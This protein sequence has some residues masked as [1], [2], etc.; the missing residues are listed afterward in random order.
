M[1]AA[2]TNTS[3]LDRANATIEKLVSHLDNY[4]QACQTPS[5]DPS[6]YERLQQASIGAID[7]DLENIR[8][9]LDSARTRLVSSVVSSEEDAAKDAADRKEKQ[10]ALDRAI[11][12]TREREA[13]AKKREE[14]LVMAITYA[15]E[16]EA[17]A[18]KRMAEAKK[19]MA[20][21]EKMTIAAQRAS[22]AAVADQSKAD[23]ELAG[24][25]S[26]R[27]SFDADFRQRSKRL[28]EE[29][30]RIMERVAS[31]S[32]SEGRLATNQQLHR[33]LELATQQRMTDAHALMKHAQD[34]REAAQKNLDTAVAIDHMT[35]RAEDSVES[36]SMN[37][38][39]KQVDESIRGSID[40]LCSASTNVSRELAE[41][42]TGIGGLRTVTQAAETVA[43][44]LVELQ[45]ATRRLVAEFD[46]TGK[47]PLSSQ[48]ERTGKRA[49]SI[50]SVVSMGSQAEV[51]PIGIVSGGRVIRPARSRRSTSA[52][53]GPSGSTAGPSGP[54]NQLAFLTD[55][56]SSHGLKPGFGVCPAD[57]RRTDD[58]TRRVW[59][60]ISFGTGWT[61]TDSIRL[62]EEF[63]TYAAK[64]VSRTMPYNTL[65][66]CAD[67][68]GKNAN[69]LLQNI[70]KLGSHWNEG[71][72]KATKQCKECT[73]KSQICIRV[74]WLG[75][76]HEAYD[77]N[78]TNVKRWNVT[79]R[80]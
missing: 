4:R 72:D 7:K 80:Q 32:S 38:L 14:R 64:G 52:T 45:G 6:I 62:L 57:I 71:E 5:L 24:M 20:D 11:L 3:D 21:A 15:R 17:E 58:E 69:C 8:Q 76:S 12:T 70:R 49:K 65:D 1:A 54:S 37:E 13:D 22:D 75:D 53:A 31:I 43:E 25:E 50:E 78:A 59:A 47:R 51:A 42:S 63:N 67:A 19:M 55:P 48:A 41:V 79:K 28:Q 73:K 46:S 60:Q 27:A 23:S 36:N 56:A 40:K 34:E 44:G 29:E 77:R 30:T 18:D 35:S 26:M 33:Q 9:D 74:S 16:K 61:M 39:L 66:R 2:V 10:A 68:T